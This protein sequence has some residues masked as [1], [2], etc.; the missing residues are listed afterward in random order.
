MIFFL[1]TQGGWRETAR[2]EHSGPDGGPVEVGD[3]PARLRAYLDAVALRQA[4][5]AGLIEG[6]AT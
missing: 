6:E 3:G 2:V 5:A 4:E 1:K